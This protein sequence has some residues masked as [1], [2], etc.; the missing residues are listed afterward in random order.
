MAPGGAGGSE[1]GDG[2]NSGGVNQSGGATFHQASNGGSPSGA[3]DG[4][5]GG[6]NGFA[7][8]TNQSSLPSLTGNSVL[9]ISTVSLSPT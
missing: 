4:G 1:A 2:G 8:M 6:A 7:L 3:A 9:G 5:L